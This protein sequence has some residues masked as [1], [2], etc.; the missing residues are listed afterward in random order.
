MENILAAWS[1]DGRQIAV[2]R[3]DLSVP[4]GDQ[5]WLMQADGSD[6]RAITDTPAVLH[7]SLSWSPDG[8]YILH[9]LY[10]LDSFPLESRLEMIEVKNGEITDLNAPGYNPKWIWLP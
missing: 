3:R 9:D 7:G 8:K 5:I 4:R 2:V 6:P 1:P 10:L